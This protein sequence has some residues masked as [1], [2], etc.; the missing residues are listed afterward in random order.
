MSDCLQ[1]VF[2]L[3][4]DILGVEGVDTIN[5]ALDEFNLRVAKTMLVGDVVGHT[6]L[7]TRFTAGTTGL[8]LE[9]FTSL[10]EGFKT[11]L[12]PAGQVNVDGSPHAGAKVGGA[13]VDVAVLGVKHEALAALGLDGVTDGLDTAGKTFEDTLDITTLLHGDDSELILFIDPDEERL[14]GV[15]EDTTAFGPVALHTGNLKV[16]IS[17]YEEEVVINELLADGFIHASQGVVVASEVTRELAEGSLHEVLNTNALFLGDTRGKT[18]AINAATNTD[19]D[20]VDG[21]ISV[22]VALD[23]VDVHV[24]GVDGVGGDTV[25]F[26]DD[27]IEDIA[28][29]LVGIPITSVDTAVLVIEINSAGNGLSKGE[30]G[31]GGLD[32]GE[33]LPLFLGDVLGD[34]RVGTLDVREWFTHP[35]G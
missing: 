13:G 4:F 7:A 14:L 10:L 16:R 9:L 35:D 33:L 6:G 12:G 24:G 25:V 27:G 23:L 17:G 30:A 32:W 18:E 20:G 22:N 5:H 34:Q 11:F 15:V 21:D 29:V 19:P 26:L 2:L 3:E 8:N 1:A 31:G 28:E